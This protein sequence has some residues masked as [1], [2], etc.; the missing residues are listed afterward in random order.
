MEITVRELKR[1]DKG[2][3]RAMVDVE[4]GGLLVRGLHVIDNGQGAWIAWPAKKWIG[5]DGQARY[6]NIVEPRSRELR[7]AIAGE[8]LRAWREQPR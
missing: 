4:V 2:S 1:V 8:V 6:T 5:R 3:L 7:D